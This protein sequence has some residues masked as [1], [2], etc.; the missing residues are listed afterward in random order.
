[1]LLLSFVSRKEYNEKGEKGEDG[2]TNQLESN[3]IQ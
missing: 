2:L 3:L 1:M